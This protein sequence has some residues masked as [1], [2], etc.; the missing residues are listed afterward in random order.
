MHNQSYGNK[1]ENLRKQ[2]V[3]PGGYNCRVIASGVMLGLSHA[4]YCKL[5]TRTFFCP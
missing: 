1:K 5:Q 4:A 3:L 2:G